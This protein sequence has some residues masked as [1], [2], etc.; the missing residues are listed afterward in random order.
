MK[1]Y[2]LASNII[3]GNLF[4]ELILFCYLS[5]IYQILLQLK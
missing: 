1:F 3:I 5:L 4:I 2:I